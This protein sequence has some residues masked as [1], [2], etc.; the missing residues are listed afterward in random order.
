MNTLTKLWDACSR[1]AKADGDS[2]MIESPRQKVIEAA[3]N[4]VW[5]QTHGK[6]HYTSS[7]D[8][9]VSRNNAR[10]ELIDAVKALEKTEDV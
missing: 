4:W 6:Y 3:K 1:G 5:H 10:R 8:K 9:V 2:A 7:E